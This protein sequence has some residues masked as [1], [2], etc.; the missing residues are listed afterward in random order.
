MVAFVCIFKFNTEHRTGRTLILKIWTFKYK[1][2]VAEI[3]H[4]TELESNKRE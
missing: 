3:I 2:R 1:G 4:T